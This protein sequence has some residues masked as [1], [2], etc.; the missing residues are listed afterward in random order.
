VLV[1]SVSSILS[2]NEAFVQNRLHAL[3][4]NE[5]D[6]EV[7]Y[8]LKIFTPTI[9]HY[10]TILN[11]CLKGYGR[12]KKITQK[13]YSGEDTDAYKNFILYINK[14]NEKIKRL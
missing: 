12:L 2:N 4:E 13:C 1:S 8:V 3:K 9:E 7:R 11:E 6:E 5:H 14:P 10:K